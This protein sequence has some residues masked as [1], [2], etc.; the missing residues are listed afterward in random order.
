MYARLVASCG[1]RWA[2]VLVTVINAALLV[3]VVMF[4][5]KGFSRFSYLNI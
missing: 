1:K 5:D 3:L 4:A 2:D